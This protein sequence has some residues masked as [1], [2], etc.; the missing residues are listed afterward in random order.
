ML[1]VSNFSL[2]MLPLEKYHLKFKT[3][4]TEEATRMVEWQETLS[5]IGNEYVAKA[6]SD[7]LDVYIPVHPVSV[8]QVEWEDMLVW[9]YCG[10]R[11]TRENVGLKIPDTA[12][13]WIFI[14]LF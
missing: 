13:R 12:Y 7:I 1:L 8:S 11:L 10:D 2:Q 3:I 6:M 14:T 5:C 4:T 9:S